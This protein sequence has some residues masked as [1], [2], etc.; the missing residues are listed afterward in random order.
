MAKK[1]KKQK[2]NSKLKARTKQR[3]ISNNVNN[4]VQF[5]DAKLL[6]TIPNRDKR[7]DYIRALIVDMDKQIDTIGVL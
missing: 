6:V 1:T 2:R 3:V 5:D 4:L 7:L